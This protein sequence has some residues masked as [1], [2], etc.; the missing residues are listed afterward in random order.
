[1]ELLNKFLYKLKKLKNIIIILKK[2]ELEC[3]LY[4]CFI[5]TLT[6]MNIV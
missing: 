1:M 5:K 6:L 4:K 2:L 3:N